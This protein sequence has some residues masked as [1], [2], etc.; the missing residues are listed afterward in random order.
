M[1]DY[2]NLTKKQE[3]HSIFLKKKKDLKRIRESNVN[4]FYVSFIKYARGAEWLE[5]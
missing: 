4:P 2:R 3:A 1:K 5:Q